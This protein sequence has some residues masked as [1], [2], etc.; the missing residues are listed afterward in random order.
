MSQS[1]PK[2]A[3]T[4]LLPLA[5]LGLAACTKDP[6]DVVIDVAS[7]EPEHGGVQGDQP[8][9]IHGD[10]RT[11]IGYTVYFGT[12]RSDHVS[13]RSDSELVALAPHVERPGKVDVIVI[14]DT[15]PGFRIKQAFL[16]QEAGGNIM[17]HVGAGAQGQQGGQ[18]GGNLAY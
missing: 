6:K 3:L 13:V 11:D 5:A 7:L 2:L 4:A 10:F 18:G 9:T 17:E 12:S 16:Y 15:G 1:L 8:V 14:A